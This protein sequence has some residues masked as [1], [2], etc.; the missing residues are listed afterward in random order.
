LGFLKSGMQESALLPRANSSK[1]KWISRLVG[2]PCA[3]ILTGLLVCHAASFGEEAV[4]VSANDDEPGATPGARPYEMAWAGRNA[5]THE[6]LVDFEDLSGWRTRC[7][8]GAEAV[9][10]RSRQELLFG[11][12][13]VKVVYTGTS[14]RSSFVLEPPDPIAIPILSNAVNLWVRG[15]N[16]RWENPPRTARTEVS[17][18]LSDSDGALYRLKMG[19]V[20][21]DYWFLFHSSLTAL[22]GRTPL[23]HAIGKSTESPLPRPVFFEGIEVRG[24]SNAEAAALFF[25]ALSFYQTES[26]PLAFA[27]LPETLD[28]PTTPDTILPTQKDE[29]GPAPVFEYT[30]SD[31]TLGDLTVTID[32]RTFQPCLKGG[33]RFEVDGRTLLAGHPEFAPRFVGERKEGSKRYYDWEL[34]ADGVSLKYTFG[35]EVKGKSCIIDV[36]AEDGYA[37]QLDI[38]LQKGLARAKTV[39][40]PY[41]TYS[42]DGW[43]RLLCGEGDSGPIFLLALMD[44]Y[45]SDASELFGPADLT[46]PEA[47]GYTGGARYRPTTAGV[48][49][50]MHERIFVNVSSDVQEVL[51]NIPNPDCDTGEL[52]WESLCNN[53]GDAGYPFPYQML[54]KYKTYGI[55]KYIVNHHENFWRQGGESFTLRDEPASEIGTEALQAYGAFVRGLGYRFGLYSNYADLA[56]VNANWDE[57]AVCLNPDGTWLLAWP[58]NYALKPLR[59]LELE[60][61]YASQIHGRYQTTASCIDVH[62]AL[63]PWERTDYDA[64]TPGAAMFRTQFDAYARL[65]INESKL[66]GGP[67]FSEGNYH[68]FYAGISDGN[69]ATILPF[70]TGHETPPLVDFDLLKMHTKMTDLGMGS[71][72][73]FYGY[74]GEWNTG[75]SRLSESFDRFIVATIAYGHLGYL[76]ESW[77]FDGLLKCYYLLQALQQRYVLVPVTSIGYFDGSRLVNTSE[78][79]ATDALQRGQIQTVYQNGLTTWCNLSADDTWSVEV[80]GQSYLLPPAS[81]VAYRPGDIL[82][83]SAIVNGHRNDLVSCR[84]YLYL[85]SRDHAVDTGVVGATGAVAIKPAEKGGWWVIPAVEAAGVTIDLEWLGVDGAKALMAQAFDE[86]GNEVWRAPARCTGRGVEVPDGRQMGAMKLRLTCADSDMRYEH[87]N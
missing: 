27:A 49:N 15:N 32:G 48:R 21:F 64:R 81:F 19:V 40:V 80:A 5:P 46:A 61:K 58:R 79:I 10:Y 26:A 12:H 37:L 54:R 85:D 30:P 42:W 1:T 56:P 6:Q 8:E 87:E 69:Y 60:V 33:V 70:G 9:A 20:D 18:L 63:T 83:Y 57:N 53:L 24:C 73:C 17:V 84:D 78:A 44:Y 66:H 62:T 75:A 23:Y 22:D 74:E 52:A 65:L 11:E 86:S 13:T 3:A 45:N 38:G 67:A 35:L 41:L 2:G 76:A 50:P 25:D 29:N 14:E 51:P 77:G 55:D 31:G 72:F 59:A 43:P 7:T 47:L 34:P 82:A 71:P 4:F 16:W 39:K 36:T 28:W 68:W